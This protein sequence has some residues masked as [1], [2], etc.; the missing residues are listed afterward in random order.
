GLGRGGGLVVGEVIRLR[1]RLRWFERRP[2]FG[3]RIVVTRPRA[4]AARFA[5]VLEA[6]GAAVVAL[7]TIRLE[8]PDDW[9]PLDGA[10]ARLAMFGWVI[11]TSA[12]GVAAF[13]ERLAAARLDARALAGARLAAIGPETAEA[14]A[15][16]G[17]RADVV[18]T[19]YRAEG[20]VESLRGHIAP[21][22][23]AL[24]VRAAEARE[25][26]PHELRALG[27]RLTVVPAYRTVP[28]KEGADAVIGLLET[29]QVDAVTFTSSSAVRAFMK[30]LAPEEIRRLLGGVVLAAIGPVT[31]ATIGEYG[32]EVRVMPREYTIPALAD[33]IAAYFTDP[34]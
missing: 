21:G 29:R 4:Q 9:G 34:T 17:L 7:P 24:L 33:A 5:G 30:L 11:F 2:L 14:L 12:N 23:E 8:P 6:Y 19:E 26:L 28:V 20:L 27:T 13:R 22:S 16:G 1:P 10:I 31:A 18:P 3:R 15:R 32:L 25:V